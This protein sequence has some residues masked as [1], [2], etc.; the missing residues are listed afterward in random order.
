MQQAI[1]KNVESFICGNEL[2]LK[3]SMILNPVH[4]KRLLNPRRQAFDRCEDEVDYRVQLRSQLIPPEIF[5][6][7]LFQDRMLLHSEIL[8]DSGHG[9]TCTE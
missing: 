7:F 2:T 9:S 1:L 8:T 6:S 3:L 4:V 5:I